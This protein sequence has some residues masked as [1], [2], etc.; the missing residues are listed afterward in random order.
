MNAHELKHLETRKAKIESEI[1]SHKQIQSDAGK[2]ITE[3]SNQKQSLENE[4]KKHQTQDLRV[5]EHALLRLCERK[6]ELPIAKMEEAIRAKLE[7]IVNEFGN[8][9]YPIGDGLK[10][11]VKDRVVV[12]IEAAA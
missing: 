10:A 2:R 4:I 1:K 8:G 7:P 5:S 11:I 3:L 12:T 6:F 9:K